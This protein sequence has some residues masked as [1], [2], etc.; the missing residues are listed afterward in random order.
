MRTFGRRSE[1]ANH[2]PVPISSD[3]EVR[4]VNISASDIALSDSAERSRPFCR[5]LHA[6]HGRLQTA[7]RSHLLTPAAER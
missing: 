3:N 6:R 4:S 7:H 2:L 5:P 1:G